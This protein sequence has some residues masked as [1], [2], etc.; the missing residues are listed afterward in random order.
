MGHI[1]PWTRTC[2]ILHVIKRGKPV[3]KSSCFNSN[4][5]AYFSYSPE[6]QIKVSTLFFLKKMIDL[7]E[8][9]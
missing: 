9:R 5:F 1:E 6:K 3:R 8:N 7:A 4:R 2:N